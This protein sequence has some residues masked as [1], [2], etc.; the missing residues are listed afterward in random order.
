MLNIGIQFFGGRGSGGGKR[1]GSGGGGSAIKNTVGAPE[2]AVDALKEG[3]EKAKTYGVG[4]VTINSS[5]VESKL[6]TK[7]AG[8]VTDRAFENKLFDLANENGY[9][10]SFQ[11]VS[12]SSSESQTTKNGAVNRFVTKQKERVANFYKR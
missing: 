12:K 5:S 6:G 3:M 11:T 4:K 7:S 10:V 9:M 1:A 8:S 2:R